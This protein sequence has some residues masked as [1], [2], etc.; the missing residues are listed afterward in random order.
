MSANS[1]DGDD[2]LETM[3]RIAEEQGMHDEDDDDSF[4]TEAVFVARGDSMLLQAFSADNGNCF[5]RDESM[6]TEGSA[7]ENVMGDEEDPYF[8]PDASFDE[9]LSTEDRPGLPYLQRESLS[10]RRSSFVSTDSAATSQSG[11]SP[12][13]S[14]S[15][16]RQGSSSAARPR[17]RQS[18][19]LTSAARS[20]SLLSEDSRSDVFPTKLKTLRPLSRLSKLGPSTRRAD[21]NDETTKSDVGP[22]SAFMSVGQMGNTQLEDAAAAAAVVAYSEGAASSKRR[23]FVVDDSVLV[24]LN[25]LN[26]TNSVDPPEAFTV[27]PVNKFG[28]PPGEGK[29]QAEQQGPYIYVMATVKRVHFDEDVPYYTVVRADTGAEQR[30]DVVWMEPLTDYH[31]IEAATRAAHE[32]GRSTIDRPP[33]TREKGGISTLLLAWLLWPVKFARSTFVP[34]YQAVKEA[35]KEK[36]RHILWGDAPFYCKIRITGVNILVLCSFIYL[37]IEVTALAFFPAK[38]DYGVAV[39]GL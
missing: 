17:R 30:A 31:G 37:F 23:Q 5:R 33:S 9:S 4:D 38:W 36:I 39:A 1:D 29:R 26:H 19:N 10:S 28:F 21:L 7:S 16:E 25:I 35:S 20:A 3:E 22:H 15:L 34:W 14:P 13:G 11:N 32:T 6:G 8:P 2:M 27:L 24:F 12:R 18:I